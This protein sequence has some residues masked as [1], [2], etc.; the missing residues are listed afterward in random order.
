V[1]M[2]NGGYAVMDALAREHGGRGAWG[3]F[4]H[5]D[6][7]AIATAFGCPST[8]VQTHEQLLST[9]DEVIPTLR[10]RQQPLLIEVSVAP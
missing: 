8:R 1:V 5:I 4:G 10:E 3:S 9:L 6:I 2:A 7:A